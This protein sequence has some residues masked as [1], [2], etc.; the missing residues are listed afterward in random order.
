MLKY[1]SLKKNIRH[2]SDEL[3]KLKD[4]NYRQ[5]L[6]VSDFDRDITRL[7]VKVNEHTDIQRKLGNEYE[8][9]KKYLGNVI[10][11]ISHDFQYTADSFGA[12]LKYKNNKIFLRIFNTLS[13]SISVDTGRVFEPFYRMDSRTI[14]GSG[15]GLYVV[16][17][18]CER[19]G[20]TVS[21]DIKDG[22]FEVEIII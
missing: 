2:F 15:L 6:K 20:W 22:V 12:V 8:Q 5:P 11:G 17:Q 9:S 10:S 14:G 19:L 7:A 16:K 21:A 18:L 1:Y 13:D 4:S 3:E